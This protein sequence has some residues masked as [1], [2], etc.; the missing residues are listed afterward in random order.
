[1][2]R[3]NTEQITA[4]WWNPETGFLCSNFTTPWSWVP[5]NVRI[6]TN[7]WSQI[8]SLSVSEC[9][10][11][12]ERS[13]VSRIL[14]PK[15]TPGLRTAPEYVKR[16]HGMV[17]V[18]LCMHLCSSSS[19]E[20]SSDGFMTWA[21]NHKSDIYYQTTSTTFRRTAEYNTHLDVELRSE[22]ADSFLLDN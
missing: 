8:V 22:I 15:P 11:V 2:R 3:V 18:H 20:E 21:G 16:R 19:T 5:T 13:L 10:Q 12:R 14:T 7:P 9:E 1:M 4:D 6:R 17:I